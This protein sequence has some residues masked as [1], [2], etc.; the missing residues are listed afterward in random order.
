MKFTNLGKAEVREGKQIK[1]VRE[2]ETLTLT[3][4]LSEDTRIHSPINNYDDRDDCHTM[5]ALRGEFCLDACSCTS[6]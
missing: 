4:G 5:N 1:L 3:G 2:V 6:N